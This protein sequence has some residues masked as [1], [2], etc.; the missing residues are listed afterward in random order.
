M[1]EIQKEGDV[2]VEEDEMDIHMVVLCTI[3]TKTY[4]AGEE[5][6]NIPTATQVDP[7]SKTEDSMTVLGLDSTSDTDTST[8]VG[9]TNDRLLDDFSDSQHGNDEPGKDILGSSSDINTEEG[10]VN[11]ET[12]APPLTVQPRI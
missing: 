8:L 5:R 1:S 10:L 12:E 2:L 7:M 4:V 9:E 11:S 6:T 3:S